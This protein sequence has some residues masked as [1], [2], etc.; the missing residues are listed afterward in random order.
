[1]VQSPNELERFYAKPD[2]WRFED[3]PEDLGRRA[4]LLSVIPP[5]RY[6]QVLDIGCGDGF[7]TNRLPGESIIGVDLSANAVKYANEKAGPRISYMQKSLFD[8]SHI[9]WKN[10]FDLIVITGVL[11]TQY[12]GQAYLLVS[13]IVDDLL[14]SDGILIC[15]HISE[16]YSFRFPYTTLAREYYQYREYTHVL[17][18]YL[19]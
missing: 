19:K 17:E 14:Q 12:V 7:I 11:Y 18:V 5:K 1:M 8:L 15:S 3:N 4:R 2:P 9:Q 16:W 10:K 13:T 6:S